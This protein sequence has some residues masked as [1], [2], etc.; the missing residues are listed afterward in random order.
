M[1]LPKNIKTSNSRLHY[2]LIL[3]AALI[4]TGCGS[5]Q[6]VVREGIPEWVV[7][8]DEAWQTITPE[9][10]GIN[11]LEAWNRWV[12]RTKEKVKGDS[13]YRSSQAR[14]TTRKGEDHSGSNWGVA[15]A[16][17]G[18]LLQTFGDPDFKFQTASLG[19]SF[20]LACLQLAI[21]DDLIG[22]AD[23]LIKDVWT[24]EGQL[25]HPHKYLNQ[26]HHNSLT[27]SHLANHVGGF[28][29]TNGESWKACNDYDR[30]A[31]TARSLGPT[32]FPEWANCTG[33]A[34]HDNY[35]HAEPD[36]VGWVYSSGGYWRL[37]QALT[38][39]WKKDLKVVMD[40]RLFSKMGIPAD[41]WNWTPGQKVRED[42]GWYPS[43]PGYGLFLDPPY[44]IDG[45]VVR[46]GPG[47]VVMS[48]K[49]L[50]RVGLLVAT[51]GEW[52]GERLISGTSFLRGHGGG[53]A[54]HMTGVGGD[55]M[56]SWG[57]VTTSGINSDDL[58]VD[59]FVEQ[60]SAVEHR[61]IPS[62]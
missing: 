15:I 44:E 35:A 11:D 38:A 34:D 27:F 46:G 18:Y 8:P 61:G 52:K 56:V 20:T 45:N 50:A 17:G 2:V 6:K 43:M 37:A 31:F 62:Q 32:G 23:D 53:N 21:E 16:R 58:P 12:S 48:A 60:Y 10:A 29:I 9:E 57:K 26:G 30:V 59:L 14:G 47:W 42:A 51:R 49:D 33:D 39:V 25:N 22:S 13:F 36:S 7:Y 5:E 4:S 28:P 55:L 3:Q 40:E 19:K 1:P 54:S 41:R 24:G